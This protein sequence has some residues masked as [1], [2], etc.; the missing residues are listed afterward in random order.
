MTA[1]KRYASTFQMIAVIL[2]EEAV[3]SLLAGGFAVNEDK[4]KGN[5]DLYNRIRSACKEGV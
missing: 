4:C 5:A 2:D 1:A 3:P